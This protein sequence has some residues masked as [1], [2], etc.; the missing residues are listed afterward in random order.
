M[1]GIF[2]GNPFRKLIEEGIIKGENLYS[3][4]M[5][6]LISKA[7]MD[8]T[9]EN[10]VRLHTVPSIRKRGFD[11]F[12]DELIGKLREHAAIYVTFDIDSID[13]SEVNGT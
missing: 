12:S 5:R 3:V 4:G 8:F 11:E 9:L 2:H 10:G 1:P 7:Q 13:P 6:G